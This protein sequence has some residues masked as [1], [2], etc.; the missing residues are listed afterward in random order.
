MVRSANFANNESLEHM[1]DFVDKAKWLVSCDVGGQ[2]D[3]THSR[4]VKIVATADKTKEGGEPGKITF[5][6][7][8]EASVLYERIIGKRKKQVKF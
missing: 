7:K 5:T 3:V 6:D 8:K 1:A 2:E 4:E